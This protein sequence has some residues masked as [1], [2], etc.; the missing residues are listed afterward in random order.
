MKF[1]SRFGEAAAKQAF[2]ADRK[3]ISRWRQRLKLSGGK[4]VSLLPSSTRPKTVRRPLTHLKIVDFIEAMRQD[5]PRI[6]KDKIKPDLDEYCAA[7]GIPTISIS[8]IGNVIKRHR[9][10][11]QKSGRVYHNPNHHKGKSKAELKRLRQKHAPKPDSL[12]HLEM[13]S[14]VKFIDGMKVYLI[15]AIDVKLKFAFCLAL[16]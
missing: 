9:L 7:L 5:H 1:Y 11:F 16:C 10:F 6:G 15:T 14:L 13:D 2:G 8:T 12:G 4:L 3:V